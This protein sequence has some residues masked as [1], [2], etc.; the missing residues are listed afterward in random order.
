MRPVWRTIEYGVRALFR[1][2]T[3][4]RDLADEV[5]HFMEEAEADLIA[6]GV[7]PRE[8]RRAVRLR[9]GDPLTA[10]EDVRTSGWEGWVETLA[11]DIRL[12][13][14]NLRR[15]P[16]FTAVVVLTLAL[17]VGSA[18]A[19]FSVVRP[20]LFE[21][22]GYPDPDR[23]L[24]I[25]S[26]GDDGTPVQSAYGTFL[27]LAQRSQTFQSL[28][29]LK[30]WQPTLTGLSE[31]QRLEGQSV[32]AGYFDVLGV[33]PILGAGFD[34]A[35]DLPGGPRAVVLSDA[36]WRDRFGA[37][38]DVVGRALRLDGEP[39]V[40]VGIMPSTFENVTAPGA[41]LWTLLQ[42]DP[43]P[44]S[45]ETREW[46]H[47]LDV[48]G[49]IRRGTTLE[50][51]RG[52]LND[53]AQRA[54]TD[55]PR[56]DWASLVQGLSVRP[57]R[58]ATVAEARPT[59][60]AVLG[61]VALLLMV[62]CANI[63]LLL[64]ARGARRRDEFALRAALG[65]GRGRLA[66]YL[67]TESL[68]LSVVGGALGLV[69]ADAG[70]S[71]LLALSPASLPRLNA[72]GIDGMA[73]AFALGLTTL[74]GV[75]FGLVPGLHRSSGQPRSLRGSGRGVVRRSRAAR[76]VLVTAEVAT[77]M[78]LLV[79]SGLIL[80][81]TLHLF[82]L[83]LGFQ[84][85][86]RMVVQVYGTGLE[87][88]DAV[89]HRFFDDALDAVRALPGVVSAAETSQ[90]PLS[91]EADVYGV[92]LAD[93][94]EAAE[95]VGQGDGPVYR[96]AVT[97]GYLGSMGVRV[98]QG[99]GLGDGDDASAPPVVV[100]S[101]SLASRLFGDGS[102]IG[103]TLR[104]GPPRPDPYTVVGVVD[105]VKQT[106]L[107]SEATDAVYIASHQWPWADRVRWMVVETAG[108]PISLAPAIRQAV[109]S[110]DPNQ[111]VVRA[112]PLSAVVT[113][114]EARRRFVLMILSAFAAA[115]AA[116]ATIGL[117]GLVAGM[118]TERL[119]EMGVR[120]ALGAP[121][122]RLVALVVGQG[123]ALTAAGL[124]LGG[125]ASVVATRALATF[126]FGVST[127][128]PLTYLGVAAL[129]VVGSVVACSVPAVRASR[130]DPVRTLN[131][132]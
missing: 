41:Q 87:R 86:Q 28:A 122:K 64:L 96:Y 54:V 129:L 130:V 21:P 45:F 107:A 46:G 30:S 90:L 23:V 73:L 19:I 22:L 16:G 48:V 58:D 103:R 57:L 47:H 71:A 83:P 124:V 36:F 3:A 70:V 100:V 25:G 126:L 31:P 79:G 50:G 94:T 81:S 11:A 60:L 99:R 35:A 68:M 95:A 102:P 39:Y 67:V 76:R 75:V 7:A 120:A 14:R 125:V 84:P 13:G 108:D 17:G 123:M 27:E 44:A 113:R 127:V 72:V 18:T 69:V 40:V 77:A 20:V 9:Y 101:H 5:Q 65:A 1:R 26:R 119:P 56:P 61:A 55:F 29:A 59:M 117:Y 105:D 53:I 8:A 24:A 98:R 93:G 12:S 112:Q 34:A 132:E 104:V 114:S 109:W 89:T 43:V 66:R 106:S 37:D 52:E 38:R 97:P 121:R 92:F 131:A 110:V 74:V 49:R 111:P 91:G 32:T 80:R 15:N 88:G 42:Y 115:A 6:Q 85:A 10:R 116:L 62:T 4:E 78:V 51:A 63:T 2:G 33:R 128:D 82:S 118:V